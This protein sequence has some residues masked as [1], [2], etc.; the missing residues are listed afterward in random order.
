VIELLIITTLVRGERRGEWTD[1]R[2]L[3]TPD[4][5]GRTPL[6][7]ATLFG[8]THIVQLLLSYD[9]DSMNVPTCSGRTPV[10]FAEAV[11]EIPEQLGH[12]I[13]RDHEIF[14][15]LLELLR[16]PRQAANSKDFPMK[17]HS[18]FFNDDSECSSC[19]VRISPYDY[20]IVCS[21][22][23]S[24]FDS[25]GPATCFE[26][27]APKEPCVHHTRSKYFEEPIDPAHDQ[28]GDNDSYILSD[29]E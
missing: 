16:L 8:H 5:R 20:E 11:M 12:F 19:H 24:R 6:F 28:T 27:A 23:L 9:S 22:W 26:C 4:S 14:R 1:K 3:D 13:A 25:H 10:S 7:L 15:P 17:T 18:K 2:L 29:H 21:K